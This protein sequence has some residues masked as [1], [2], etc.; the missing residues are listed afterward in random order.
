MIGKLKTLWQRFRTARPGH[1]FQTIYHERHKPTT[2]GHFSRYI[3]NI[4]GGVALVIVGL[5]LVPAPGPGLLIVAL[6]GALLAREFLVVA[7]LLDGVE[8]KLR[9]WMRRCKSPAKVAR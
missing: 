8:I 6:G 7:R 4:A 2:G 5:I 3:L 1:R 9:N